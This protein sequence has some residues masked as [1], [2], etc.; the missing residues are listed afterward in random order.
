MLSKLQVKSRFNTFVIYN[1]FFIEYIKLFVSHLLV[2]LKLYWKLLV[3][4]YDSLLKNIS[5]GNRF[6]SLSNEE[7]GIDS[8][9]NV[10]S[11]ILSIQYAKRYTQHFNW[12]RGS[13]C[14]QA[15]WHKLY[16][17]IPLHVMIHIT[18]YVFWCT[19]C[20]ILTRLDLNMFVDKY[21][22]YYKY[23]I[24]YI[25]MQYSEKRLKTI[26]SERKKMSLLLLVTKL[27]FWFI[28]F[29]DAT[30][31]LSACF[32]LWCICLNNIGYLFS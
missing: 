18:T 29:I 12:E 10:K 4:F 31:M 2:M 14:C 9:K 28:V 1:L 16:R 20:S 13:I 5:R 15:K 17:I 26:D 11:A 22:R 30:D 23:Y 21:Y 8:N 6:L 25:S 3:K 19:V 24:Y 32:F 7:N 27:L